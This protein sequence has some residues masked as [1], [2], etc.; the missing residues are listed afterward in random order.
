VHRAPEGVW[1]IEIADDLHHSRI[2][3][4]VKRRL[5]G[6]P[7]RLVTV[8]TQRGD[9]RSRVCCRERHVVERLGREDVGESCRRSGGIRLDVHPPD[10]QPGPSRRVDRLLQGPR[11]SNRLRRL[12]PIDT[13]EQRVLR[14]D[15]NADAE[16][17]Q[18]HARPIQQRRAMVHRGRR[19][20]DAEMEMMKPD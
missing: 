5:L 4:L 7:E 18:Q 3:R 8:S 15:A 2:C 9:D 19:L 12:A 10:A 20:A 16:T 6:L 14:A 11:G 17:A 13:I 1:R